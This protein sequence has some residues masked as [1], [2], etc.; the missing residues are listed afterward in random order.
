MLSTTEIEQLFRE[1]APFDLGIVAA[2]WAE[3]TRALFVYYSAEPSGEW[4]RVTLRWP[5]DQ[6]EDE[7]GLIW[8]N[9]VHESGENARI[10]IEQQYA[11]WDF[12]AE[13]A[14]GLGVE[15]ELMKYVLEEFDIP[16]NLGVVMLSPLQCVD[17]IRIAR[18]FL[19]NHLL[20]AQVDG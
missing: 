12:L 15:K 11:I 6:L 8:N 20:Y 2:V 16:E 9:M 14:D 7:S 19:Q 13:W 5:S 4:F 18:Q 17:R 3:S 10:Y 1:A